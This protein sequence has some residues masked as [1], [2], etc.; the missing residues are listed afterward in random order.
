MR[1]FKD[2]YFKAKEFELKASLAQAQMDEERA[3]FQAQLQGRGLASPF[4]PVRTVS[5][6]TRNPSDL[7]ST[8]GTLASVDP[9]QWLAPKF[10]KPKASALGKVFSQISGLAGGSS[11]SI[12]RKGDLARFLG[13]RTAAPS[14]PLHQT[15]AFRA[16]EASHSAEFLRSLRRSEA[17]TNP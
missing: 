15:R 13:E 9:R 7:T 10:L 5:S 16:E 14:L 12:K 1:K 11:R 3:K 4:Q 8:Q 17:S 6:L 2:N